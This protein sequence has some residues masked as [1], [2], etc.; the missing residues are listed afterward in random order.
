MTTHVLRHR[1]QND[2][3]SNF[4]HRKRDIIG[5][6]SMKKTWNFQIAFFITQLFFV[7]VTKNVTLIDYDVGDL[8]EGGK[9]RR[10]QRLTR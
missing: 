5:H 2:I 1:Y 4:I 3:I 6:K 7:S 9:E 8:S 10:G